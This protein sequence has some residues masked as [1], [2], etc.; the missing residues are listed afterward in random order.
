MFQSDPGV[1]EPALHES[2]LGAH[3][4]FGAF[5]VSAGDLVVMGHAFIHLSQLF[6]KG[7]GGPVEHHQ[8]GRRPESPAAF[9]AYADRRTGHLCAGTAVEAAHLCD[10]VVH[11]ETHYQIAFSQQVAALLVGHL[12]M[13]VHRRYQHVPEFQHPGDLPPGEKSAHQ[14]QDREGIVPERRLGAI[15]QEIHDVRGL[16]GRQQ[17]TGIVADHPQGVFTAAACHIG[18]ERLE[19]LA[20]FLIPLSK[21][22]HVKVLLC[23]I[24]C[25]EF[26]SGAFFHHMMET[27]AVAA[28]DPGNEGVLL[29]QRCE[30]A[31][32]VGITG[33]ITCHFSGELVGKSHHSEELLLCGRERIDHGRAEHTVYIRAAVR[34][35]AG[36]CQRAEI[37]INCREPAFTGAQQRI[38]LVFVQLG[39]A[40]AGVDRQSGAVQSEIVCADAVQPVAQPQDL[41][42]GEETVPARCDQMHIFREFPGEGAEKDRDAP[43]PEQMKVVYINEDIPA[44]PEPMTHIV[45]EQTGACRITGAL[46]AIQKIISR[47][48]EC[49]LCAFPEDREAVRVDADPYDQRVAVLLRPVEIPVDGGGLA[50]ARRGDDSRQCAPGYGPQLAAETFGDVGYIEIPFLLWHD[51]SLIYGFRNIRLWTGLQNPGG[52]SGCGVVSVRAMSGADLMFDQ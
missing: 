27:E 14:D 6:A 42:S 29:S 4:Q 7:T 25:V 51:Y 3:Q 52:G 23:I 47:K 21:P 16:Q 40:A 22:G 41:A 20:V 19:I 32:G 10:V 34:Q 38:D 9:V 44:A 1:G 12:R 31:A 5:T 37:Q 2:R 33:D 35:P 8:H 39:S 15:F 46:A 24:Q 11:Q 26:P 30:D 36:L 45:D 28:G 49:V 43:V 13:A 17:D 50:V 18:R 48:F